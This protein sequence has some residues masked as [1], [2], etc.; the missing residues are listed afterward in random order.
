MDHLVDMTLSTWQ[1]MRTRDPRR[2]TLGSAQW[3]MPYGIANRT[4]PPTADE[5]DRLLLLAREAG[6]RSI[7]TARAYGESER[8]VGLALAAHDDWRV[9]TKLA[10]DVDAAGLDLS[11]NL[12]RVTQSLEQSREALGLE[13][14]PALLLHR[15]AHR[16]AFGGKLWRTLLA[17][18]EAGRIAQLGVSAAS[19]EE[20]WAALDDPDVEILQVATSLLDLRLHRQGFFPKAR[21]AGRTVYVRSVY[22]QGVA[23]LGAARLPAFLGGLAEAMRTIERFGRELGVSARVLYLAFVRELPG[24]HPVLGC[25][26]SGQLE[27]LL[28]DWEDETIDGALLASLV[29]RLPTAPPAL[30]DPSLWPHAEPIPSSTT[31]APRP[32]TE[33][34]RT[35][36]SRSSTWIV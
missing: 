32:R 11:E 13:S 21:E 35:A 1:G 4:G 17:E 16:H 25:E 9:V 12:G 6:V 24:V 2:L 22:L 33:P 19:P 30:V 8:R 18:R 28:R 10:P 27:Q 31:L 3:G 23:H 15:Y 29:E 36:P 26:T 34:V 7:D 5:L 20:A 14:I